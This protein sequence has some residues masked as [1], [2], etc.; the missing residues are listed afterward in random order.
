MEGAWV[1]INDDSLGGWNEE[2]LGSMS[3]WNIIGWKEDGQPMEGQRE[4]DGM[5]EMKWTLNINK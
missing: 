2:G 4:L 1:E 3:W 5:D